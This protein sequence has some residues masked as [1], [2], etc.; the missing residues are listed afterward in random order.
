MIVQILAR[1]L[2]LKNSECCLALMSIFIPQLCMR[3]EE[4]ERLIAKLLVQSTSLSIGIF[5]FNPSTRCSSQ[6]IDVQT[7]QPFLSISEIQIIMGAKPP[8]SYFEALISLTFKRTGI[9]LIFQEGSFFVSQCQSIRVTPYSISRHIELLGSMRD[10][11]ATKSKV[12]EVVIQFQLL[13]AKPE[14]EVNNFV[15]NLRIGLVKEKLEPVS[16]IIS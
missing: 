13:K 7:S 1:A 9:L 4:V 2:Y 10:G 14:P 8:N 6:L 16:A 15:V 11:K 12:R 5:A 3:V